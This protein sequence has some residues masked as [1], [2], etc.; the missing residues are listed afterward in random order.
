MSADI[1]A[2]PQPKPGPTE[3]NI[4]IEYPDAHEDFGT[5]A[6]ELIDI[7]L[8]RLRDANPQLPEVDLLEEAEILLSEAWS[9]LDARRRALS[10]DDA[11]PGAA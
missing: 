2:F 6:Q 1:I 8:Q 3:P 5:W 10:G 4:L 7:A 9:R 11:G